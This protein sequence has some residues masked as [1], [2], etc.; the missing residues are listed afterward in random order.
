MTEPVAAGK[1]LVV[2]DDEVTR[3]VL[4]AALTDEGCMVDATADGRAAILR[5]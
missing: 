3:A 4:V 1:V 5:L 2:E